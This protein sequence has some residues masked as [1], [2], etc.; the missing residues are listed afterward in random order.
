VSA[1]RPATRSANFQQGENPRPPNSRW[2]PD[3]L[4]PKAPRAGGFPKVPAPTPRVY[5]VRRGFSAPAH[6]TRGGE[7][8]CGVSAG[9]C[10]LQRLSSQHLLHYWSPSGLHFY[11]RSVPSG[12]VQRTGCGACG[13]GYPHQV[14]WAPPLYLA[15]A[16]PRCATTCG[17]QPHA[18]RHTLHTP[19]TSCSTMSQEVSPS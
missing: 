6:S 1:A 17:L 10:A 9:H 13:F 11:F 16:W 7:I 15:R 18:A 12:V 8:V 5:S 19:S 3:V 4:T 14:W 2:V